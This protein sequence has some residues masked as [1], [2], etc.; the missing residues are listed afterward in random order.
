MYFRFLDPIFGKGMFIIFLSLL[1]IDEGKAFN[2]GI[3]L[4]IGTIGG[5]N[6][7]LG[8]YGVKDKDGNEVQTKQHNDP[9]PAGPSSEPRF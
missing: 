2:I 1:C 4:I 9:N 6:V 8:W 3:F 7:I 5:I